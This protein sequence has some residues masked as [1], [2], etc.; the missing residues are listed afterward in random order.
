MST[1]ALS[2]GAVRPYK[3]PFLTRL[4]E[5]VQ[6]KESRQYFIVYLVGKMIGLLAVIALAYV[7]MKFIGDKALAQDA[8]TDAPPILTG[9]DIVNPLNTA[10]VLVAA[11]LV[12]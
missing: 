2:A 9:D 8:P 5:A 1:L 10:W 6:D 3:P 11:F 4:K 7:F 12:F